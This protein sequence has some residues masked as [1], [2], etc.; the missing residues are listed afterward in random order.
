M[1]P[2]PNKTYQTLESVV[3]SHKKPFIVELR[4]YGETKKL[5]YI[6]ER[7]NSRAFDYSQTRHIQL[8]RD[9]GIE[10]LISVAGVEIT[11]EQF[12]RQG[13]FAA[14]PSQTVQSPQGR[15]NAATTLRILE[16]QLSK[17]PVDAPNYYNL[18]QR[19]QHQRAM[20]NT[21]AL[22]PEKQREVD[23]TKA[24][25]DRTSSLTRELQ[26]SGALD[27][28]KLSDE[29]LAAFSVTDLEEA[30][31]VKK[32][33]KAWDRLIARWAKARREL[34]EKEKTNAEQPTSTTQNNPT[35]EA[36]AEL[37]HIDSDPVEG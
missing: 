26:S 14:R 32:Q 28:L 12:E 18:A 36:R 16:D 27:D 7:G 25:V 20:L 9:F 8:V 35:N 3:V 33:T 6:L 4:L 11:L 5:V 21:A 37:H 10:V 22:S 31:G 13:A 34:E 2:D 23:E 1:I 24:L 19:V 30:T 15:Y 29:E 17:T